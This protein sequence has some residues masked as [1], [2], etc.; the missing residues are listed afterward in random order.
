[1]P[2]IVILAPLLLSLLS[3]L[4]AQDSA[5]TR[6][7]PASG[8]SLADGDTVVFLGDSI[9]HQCLY[10]QYIENFFFT[11][12]PDRRIRFHNAGVSGD[13]AADALVRL[14]ADVLAQNPRY[15]TILL[16]MNDGA[17]VDLDPALFT[18]YRQDMTDLIDRIEEAG[19]T[20]VLLSP[21]LF[22]HHQLSLR[23]DDETFRFADKEFSENYN[24]VLAYYGTWVRETAGRR[25]L[26]FVNLWGPLGDLTFRERRTDP[27]FTLVEDAIH[28]GAAGHAV[29][30]YSILSQFPPEKT[31]V[32]GITLLRHKGKWTARGSGARI[33]D[34]TSENDASVRLRFVATESALPWVAPKEFSE[35]DLKWGPSAPA[36]VGFDL[37]N[38]GHRLGAQ[39]LRVVGLPA[40]DYEL[41]IDGQAVGVFSHS[42]LARKI[43]LQDNASTPQYRQALEVALLNRERN[44][45]A[46]RPMRDLWSRIK[47]LR[48]SGNEERFAA[49]VPALRERIAK[50][51]DTARDYE[52]RIYEAVQPRSHTWEITPAGT[53]AERP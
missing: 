27:D 50:L 8:F 19:A 46:V 47:A 1:M 4:L 16:G 23:R 49:E 42:Q 28:P 10:T 17:Y 24:A 53:A 36:S 34:T 11:R 33:E 21:T 22:D 18:R 20:P 26:P 2:R 6:S 51:A 30:A 3:P 9:T 12:F 31:A 41:R 44:D 7:A 35:K 15:V 25:R 39:R 29:M 5:A 13:S 38:A 37:T 45:R 43:E 32:G 52:E 40:G 14:D 48:R